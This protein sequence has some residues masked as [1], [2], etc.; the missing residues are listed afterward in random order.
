MCLHFCSYPVDIF[1]PT[2]FH[3]STYFADPR[4]G[5]ESMS[6]IG[7]LGYTGQA[8][9]DQTDVYQLD[10]T[11][12]SIQRLGLIRLRP[13]NPGFQLPKGGIFA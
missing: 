12:F 9:R 5:K 1:P 10:L 8:S 11:D 2:D 4:T 7:G 6:I 3:T 13:P